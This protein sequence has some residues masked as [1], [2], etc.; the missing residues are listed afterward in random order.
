LPI[1]G[2]KLPHIETIVMGNCLNK[3]AV[4]ICSCSIL[5]NEYMNIFSLDEKG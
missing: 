4:P 5:R 3:L 1:Y 2:K